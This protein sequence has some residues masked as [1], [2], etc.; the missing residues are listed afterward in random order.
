M[1][2]RQKFLLLF[3]FVSF[4]LV[5]S[6]FA[7]NFLVER[8][9]IGGQAYSGIELKYNVIDMVARTRVNWNMLN[10]EVKTLILDEYDEDNSVPSFVESISEV[11]QEMETLFAGKASEGGLHCA[12]CHSL[13]R[14]DALKSNLASVVTEWRKMVVLLNGTILPALANED[15]ATARETFDEYGDGYLQVM[16]ASKKIVDSLR[17]SLE[18]MKEA[19]KNEAQRFS[20]FFIV[21]GV[22]VGV[23]VLVL[24]GLTVES[25]VRELK[26][27]VETVNACATGII[28][29]TDVTAKNSEANAEIATGIAAALEETSS[30]L[31]EVSSMVRHNNENAQ[32][33]NASM[34]DNI[35]VIGTATS[36]VASML[37]SMDRIKSDSDKISQIIKDI[38]GIA[39]QTNLLALN[40]AVEAAR[41]GEAGAGFAVVA[42]EVRNLAQRTAESARNTQQLIETATGNVRQGLGQAGKV[43]DAMQHI[44]A[45]TKKTATLVDEISKA[46]SQQTQGIG[47]INKA[48]SSMEAQTQGL[49]AGTEELS[50]ASMAVYS[51]AKVLYQA[52]HGLVRLVEGSKAG[53]VASAGMDRVVQ[54]DVPR[55]PGS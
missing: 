22:V 15:T 42:D 46:S 6:I 27:I 26:K 10:S 52:T 34:N 12:S 2:I 37:S 14:A 8:V 18:S 17:E 29:E 25:I 36:D 28:G 20:I 49:A 44:A 30:S 19:K 5:G 1:S 11:L 21:A 13:D 54:G 16:S 50:A 47:Q 40:A 45:S 9:K 39:F 41:A 33:A 43:N 4:A 51:Q 53:E 7:S 32:L 38:D 24:S 23:M 31:E 55:L 35:G 48:T 3:G